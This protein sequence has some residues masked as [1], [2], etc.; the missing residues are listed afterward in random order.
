M[1]KILFCFTDLQIIASR[2]GGRTV[3]YGKPSFKD[4]YDNFI[5]GNWVAPVDGEYF[6]NHSPIIDPFLHNHKKNTHTKL[7]T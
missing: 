2:T 6:D 7:K 3:A 4:H 1:D 5:G